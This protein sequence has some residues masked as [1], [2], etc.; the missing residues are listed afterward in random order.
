MPP[1]SSFDTFK[2]PSVMKQAIHL[3]CCLQ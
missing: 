3:F 2:R 1:L